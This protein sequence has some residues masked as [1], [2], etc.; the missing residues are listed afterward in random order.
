[1]T[2]NQ[3]EFLKS[4]SFGVAGAS[5]N[6]EKYGNIVFRALLEY[7]EG[8]GRPVFPI[9]PVLE[10]VEGHEAYIDPA[11]IPS[12]PEALSIITPPAATRK[13]VDGAIV[14]GVKRIWMQPGAEDD[15]AIAAAKAANIEVIAGGPCIL[16][17]LKTLDV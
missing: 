1:M 15:K 16:V 6:R 4:K 5:N 14:V 12:P 7:T 2:A 3:I 9:H 8:D 17:A 11:A 13:V 10:K